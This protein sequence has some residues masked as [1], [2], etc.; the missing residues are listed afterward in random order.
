[1][2]RKPRGGLMAERRPTAMIESP[3][4]STVPSRSTPAAPMVITVTP[5]NAV[6]PCALATA[7]PHGGAN[8]KAITSCVRRRA[9]TGRPRTD[10]RH[11]SL[12]I[13]IF[14]LTR[15]PAH[16]G[17]DRSGDD[18]DLVTRGLEDQFQET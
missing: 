12:A 9:G 16:V 10:T 11:T 7:G 1:M 4:T 13:C 6:P 5:T 2:M 8:V 3:R 14:P 18:E 17:A 15:D